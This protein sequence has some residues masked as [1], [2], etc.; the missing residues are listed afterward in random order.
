MEMAGFVL[1]YVLAAW[2]VKNVWLDALITFAVLVLYHVLKRKSMSES[3]VMALI[4][5]TAFLTIDKIPYLD[6]IVTGPALR[7][8]EERGPWTDRKNLVKWVHNPGGFIP[9]TPYTQ[10]LATQFGGQIMPSFPQFSE[11]EINAIFDYI[12]TAPPPVDKGG[13]GTTQK[14]G[15]TEDSGNGE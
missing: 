4:V 1:L 5:I 9:T 7:G 6:K 8:V 15:A 12:K 14:E 3:A 13:G 10:Q 2:F 11:A